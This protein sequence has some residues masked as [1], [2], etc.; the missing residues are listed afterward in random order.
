MLTK[1]ALIECDFSGDVLDGV[2]KPDAYI[3]DAYV[4][5]NMRKDYDLFNSQ[6][7]ILGR[8][9]DMFVRYLRKESTI[10][11]LAEERCVTYETVQQNLIKIKRKLKAQLVAFM[12]G[13]RGGIS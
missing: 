11:D 2:D 13:D 7:G 3:R 8:E 1:D 5:R 12:E 6:L 10:G 4:L 9:Q